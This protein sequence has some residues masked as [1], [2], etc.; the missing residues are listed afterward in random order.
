M[1]AKFALNQSLALKFALKRMN[2]IIMLFIWVC[3]LLFSLLIIL[4]HFSAIDFIE[5]LQDVLC[6]DTHLVYVFSV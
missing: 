5:F 1:F 3:L 4:L 6:Y 2:F